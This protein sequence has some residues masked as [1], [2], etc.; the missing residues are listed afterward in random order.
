VSDIDTG[1]AGPDSSTVNVPSGGVPPA[2]PEAAASNPTASAPV[3]PGESPADASQ[4]APADAQQGESD[5]ERFQKSS[6]YKRISRQRANAERRAM[7]AEAELA[8]LKANSQQPTQPAPAKGAEIRRTDYANDQEYQ[9]ALGLA[10]VRRIAAEEVAKTRQ[11]FAQREQER[12]A[13][14]AISAFQ[15][16]AETQ[17]K[18]AGVDFN[19]DWETLSELPKVSREVADYLFLAENKAL[20]VHHFAENTAEVERISNLP[21]AQAFRELAKLDLTLGTKRPPNATKAPPPGPTVGGRAV[22]TR[23]WRQS[24][25]MKE[26]AAGFMREQEEKAKFG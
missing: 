2:A 7:R 25:D 22:H 4:E 9:Y 24:N 5:A 26:F 15:R 21:P 14:Q 12:T 20:L 23:D 8:A 13:Q 10:E 11:E 16:E 18:A 3:T 1:M 17:A 6:D 19:D